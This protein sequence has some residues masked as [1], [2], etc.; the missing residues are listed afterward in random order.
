MNDDQELLRVG[1]AERAMVPASLVEAARGYAAESRAV[2]TRRAYASDLKLFRSWCE[3]NGVAAFPATPAV[4]ALYVTSMAENGRKV[5]TIRRALAAISVAHTVAGVTSPCRDGRVMEIVKGIC[6][7][8]GVAQVRKAPVLVEA[9]RE[10]VARLPDGLRGT[11]DR[12][13]LLIGFATG[14]RRSEIV[15]LD[16]DDVVFG[17]DGIAVTL[18]RSKTDQEGAGRTV[19]VFYGGNPTTCP[20]RAL[21][22]WLE[23]AGITSGPLFRGINRWGR[24]SPLRLHPQSV[25]EI[26]Q[27][28]ADAVGLDARLFGGHSLRAGLVTSAIRAGK[29][30]H[31]VR[32]QT[33]HKP[34]S[35][36]ARYIRD[37]EMWQSSNATV[38]I[39][40]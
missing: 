8:L 34:G 28:A 31:A 9:L 7:T 5:A 12:A 40:L 38:G 30:E 14:F 3:A 20:V 16:L 25:A 22:A 21:K 36:F 32:R 13:V 27:A 35:T 19:A 23:A 10:M 33:G 6:R 11:R 17:H 15:S 1:S 39:G 29:P 4:V 24:I 26:V 2:S 37:A 18:R